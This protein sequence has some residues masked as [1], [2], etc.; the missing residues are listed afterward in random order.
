MGLQVLG[1][2]AEHST[3]FL[4]YKNEEKSLF[5]TKTRKRVY[6]L[7]IDNYIKCKSKFNSLEEHKCTL[8]MQE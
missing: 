2:P 7:L 4:T 8:L 5:T 1:F 3:H 6:L